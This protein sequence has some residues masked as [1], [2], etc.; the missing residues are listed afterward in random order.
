MKVTF[1]SCWCNLRI[2]AIQAFHLKKHLESIINDEIRLI[3]SN[4]NCYN[5][6]LKSTLVSP[7]DYKGLLTCEAD[8]F[9]RVPHLRSKEGSSIGRLLRRLYRNVSEPLRGRLYLRAVSD[10]DIVHFHQSNDAFGYGAVAYFLEHVK[11]K[12]KVVS[13]HN[14]SPEQWRESKLNLTYNMADAV[15]VTNNYFK[16]VLSAS[17]VDP[18]KIHIIPYGAALEPVN[19]EKREGAI[20][21]AGSPL[22][23]VKGFEYLASA[24]RLLKEENTIVPLKLHGFHMAGHK[25]WADNI[26]KEE[27]IED[28]VEW[29]NISSEEE[30]MNAYR[31]SQICIVPYTNYPGS[32]PVTMAMANAVPVVVSDSMGISEC[33]DGAGMVVKSRSPEE[34]ASALKEIMSNE[35]LRLS[36]GDKAR[37]YA[38]SNFAWPIVAEKT[39]AVY[40]QVLGK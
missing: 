38:E 18:R 31:S 14:L 40:Q 16:D 10:C 9:V 27:R 28:L 36:K 37:R 3:T 6:S 34:L 24:L 11:D 29:K 20:M 1:I 13:I 32:F 26:I 4:C 22:I 30:L 12:K 8:Y 39:L 2:Y 17:G 25:E 35:E 21:F 15:I 5:T 23:N 19:G 7:L 33:V